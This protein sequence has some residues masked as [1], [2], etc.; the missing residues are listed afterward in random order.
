MENL[1]RGLCVK[2]GRQSVCGSSS[3]NAR[4]LFVVQRGELDPLAGFLAEFLGTTVTELPGL[5]TFGIPKSDGWCN[6][7][8]NACPDDESILS[9][10]AEALLE[11]TQQIPYNMLCYDLEHAGQVQRFTGG[12]ATP[13]PL[14]LDRVVEEEPVLEYA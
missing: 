1:H 6:I 7:T 13:P 8:V 11:N 4:I 3:R 2:C 5:V 14:E 10:F 12:N 9:A